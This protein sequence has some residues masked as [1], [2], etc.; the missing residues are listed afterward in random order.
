MLPTGL[1][2]H[3]P[4]ETLRE[5]SRDP[6]RKWMV[7]L[8]DREKHFRL[9]IYKTQFLEAAKARYQGQDE[10]TDWVLREWENVSY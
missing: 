6:E 2:F 5:V 9:L 4:V 7:T 1:D 3:D 8:V 10:E